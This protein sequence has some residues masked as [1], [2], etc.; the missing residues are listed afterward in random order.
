[1][2]RQ[3]RFRLVIDEDIY[4]AASIKPAERAARCRRL[5]ESIMKICHK[6]VLTRKMEEEFQTFSSSWSRQWRIKMVDKKKLIQDNSS[7][8]DRP[9]SLEEAISNS[10]AT[11]KVKDRMLGDCHLL[12]AALWTDNR[13]IS[14]DRVREDFEN[15][16]ITTARI[17]KIVWFNPDENLDDCLEWLRRGAPDEDE[18]KLGFNSNN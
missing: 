4:T 8:E 11:E 17:Q 12:E 3:N 6:V 18:F 5:L 2:P 1:M 15:L 9:R 13:V 14:M 16:C 7:T 10:T